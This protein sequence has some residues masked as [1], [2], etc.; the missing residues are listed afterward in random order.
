MGIHLGEAPYPPKEALRSYEQATRINPD[1]AE[2]HVEIGYYYD[3]LADTPQ[4]AVPAFRRA[5]ALGAGKTA[6]LGL[7][8]SLAE[9]GDDKSALGVL[10]DCPYQG[11]PDMHK[12][13]N[14]IREGQWTRIP[15]EGGRPTTDS[16]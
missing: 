12:L 3:V 11:D 10:E 7:A 15:D 16:R 5:I 4:Q 9:L 8:R 6:Y 2:A 1:D 14:E 13:K